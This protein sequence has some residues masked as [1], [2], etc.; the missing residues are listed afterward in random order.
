MKTVEERKICVATY[1][2]ELGFIHY[3]HDRL[4]DAALFQKK[5]QGTNH[6]VNVWEYD[7]TIN[8]HRLYSYE[9]EM[10]FETDGEHWTSIKYYSIGAEDLV[11]Q[12]E[13]FSKQ[14]YACVRIL[15]GNPLDYRFKGD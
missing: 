1:L 12:I 9:V 10:C 2:F 13:S 6:S 7:H 14:L 3:G 11:A 15:G 8:E 5:I 4:K